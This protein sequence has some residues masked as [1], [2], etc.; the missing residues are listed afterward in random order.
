MDVDGCLA[1]MEAVSESIEQITVRG[2][3]ASWCIRKSIAQW[4]KSLTTRTEVR[5]AS[6]WEEYTSELNQVLGIELEYLDF[7]SDV[8]LPGRWSKLP[9]VRRL[10]ESGDYEH[11]IWIDDEHGADALEFAGGSPVLTLIQCD[12]TIGVTS[13]DCLKVEEMLV[14]QSQSS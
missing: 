6:T 10:C 4:F 9:A 13:S 8:E 2:S 12:P 7:S 5:W 1:P 11:V 3:W 14:D